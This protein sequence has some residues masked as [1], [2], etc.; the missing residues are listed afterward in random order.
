M[1]IFHKIAAILLACLLLTACHHEQHTYQ[2][3]VEGELVYLSSSQ[4]GKLIQLKVHR[5]EAVQAHQPIFQIDQQPYQDQMKQAQAKLAQAQYDL[6]NLQTGQRHTKLAAIEAQITSARAKLTYNQLQYQRSRYLVQTHAEQQQQL[7]LAGQNIQVAQADLQ[8]LRDNLADAKLPIGRAYQVK[9][10]EASLH[11]AQSALAEAQWTFKQTLVSA[12]QSGIIFDTYYWP[13]EQV[14]AQHA[15]AA[16][17]TPDHVKVIFFVP[18]PVLSQVHLNQ[19]VTI[20]TNHAKQSATATIRYISPNAEYTPPVI[21][22]R[23]TSAKL[24]Y[25]VEAYFPSSQ[26]LSWHPGQPVS[27]ILQ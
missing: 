4:S 19:S 20:Q 11:A 14:P 12:P 6:N 21:Y 23:Q 1:K 16:L 22:S 9:A 27:V 15:V 2:G 13:G 25:R 18:E 8:Q 5:G 10:A 7:D 3:Y 26:A 17:L 24:V